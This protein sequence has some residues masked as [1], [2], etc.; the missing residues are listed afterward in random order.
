ME[1]NMNELEKYIMRVKKLENI[2]EEIN[3]A[4]NQV[5]IRGAN[6]FGN[7]G[8]AD[9]SKM[10]ADQFL[11]L[12]KEKMPS[13]YKEIVANGGFDQLRGQDDVPD[14]TINDKKQIKVHFLL[15]RSLLL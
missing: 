5:E 8:G 6:V 11:A 9:L 12:I 7:I 3:L 14:I 2:D 13:I 10:S 4:Q 1:N 15:F